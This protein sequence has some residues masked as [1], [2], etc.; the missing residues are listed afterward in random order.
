MPGVRVR[1]RVWGA[2]LVM[3]TCVSALLTVLLALV[4]NAAT[5]TSRWPGALDE[6]RQTPWPWLAGA[7]VLLAVLAGVVMRMQL[8]PPA[9][10]NDPPPPPPAQVPPW[11]EERAQTSQAVAEV[12]RR[13]GRA[14][15]ITTSLWGA[16]GFGKTTLA[17]AVCA[18]RRVRRRFRGRIYP[19]TIGRDIRG[20]AAVAAKV[21]EVTRFITGDTTEFDDPHLAG[22]H[23]GRLLDQRPRTLLLL[24]DVWDDEQLAPFLHG[25]RSCVRLIT[26]RNPKLLPSGAH[27]IRVDDMSPETARRLLLRD[28]PPLPADLVDNLLQATGS[29]ALLLRLTNRL[30]AEQTTAGA[31]P[32]ATA[33]RILQQLRAHGPAAVDD[34]TAS[35]DLDDPRLRN[36]AVQASIGAATT[37]LPP[38]GADRFAE[39]GIFAEDESVPIPLICLLWQATGN[40]SEHQ[41]RS[42]CRELQRLSL[43]TL[44]PQDGGRVGLHDVIRDYLRSDLGTTGLTHTNRALVDAIAATLPPAQSLAPAGPSPERQWWHLQDGYLLDHLISHLMAAD[45]TT[46]AEAVTGDLRWVEAR[47]LHRGPSAPWNDLTRIDTPHTRPLAH[48]IA[49][50]SHLLTPTNPRDA[51]IKILHHRLDSHPHWRPQISERRRNPAARPYLI[52]LWPLPDT[53]HAAFQQAL[54]GHTYE[55]SS[56]AVSPDGAWLATTGRDR[57]V[58][59]WDR[60]TGVCTATFTGHSGE[61]TSVAISPDGVWLATAGRNGTVRLWDRGTGVCTATFTGHSDSVTSVAISPDGAWL[62]TAGRDR[63]VRLWDRATGEWTA[64]LTDSVTSVAI[65]PDGVWLATA[66]RD[67]AVRLWDRGT[68]AC[69][70]TLAGHSDSVTSVAISPDGTW[71]AT[72]SRDTTVRI[73]DFMSA[74]RALPHTSDAQGAQ[75]VA[76]S[77]DG[78]WLATTGRDSRVWLWDR[79]TGVCTAMLTGHSDGV[80]AVAV[81][82]D[83]AWLATTGYDKTVRLWDRGTG[84]CTATFTGHSDGVTSVAISPDGTWLATTGRDGTVRL[85]DRETGVCTAT[86]ADRTDSV[87]SVVISPDGTWLATTGDNDWFPG[88][89]RTVRIWDRFSGQCTATLTGHTEVVTSVAIS[90][91]G[92]WLAT[93]SHDRTVRLWDRATHQCTATLTGHTE[94]GTW[95][96]ISPDGTWLATISRDDTLR[97]WDVVEQRTAVM[98]R[99]EGSLNSCTWGPDGYTIAAAGPRGIYLL[100]LRT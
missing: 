31:E 38:A 13:G 16:G 76:I 80:T 91:D 58:R 12:C 21:A 52:S 41:T 63:T 8:H 69:T 94:A 54:T 33:Q 44:T 46:L 61:V 17:T 25:G 50:L 56:V 40:L 72:T 55:V 1:G 14:V 81:S 39:L 96:A 32:L 73:W 9:G 86:L 98:T 89:D 60:G 57:T 23:L 87:T 70:A 24:D 11:F 26:T 66:G 28:L 51:L 35:W 4:G 99:F 78:A 71:L 68:G 75:S 90:P 43:L 97:I 93:T 62:A 79:G 7:T 49:Q 6:L 88:D 83:G 19:V 65:S 42:L 15:G 45:R 59:L 74:S 20:R 36:Q 5:S 3:L 22:A 67:G 77:P 85:W 29:W 64:T 84:V 30:I 47:L 27:P 48:S 37:L 92:T 100:A 34:N 18:H 82:P 53:P 10:H 2:A 95:V